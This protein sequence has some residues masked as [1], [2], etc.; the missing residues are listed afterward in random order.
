[1]RE[2]DGERGGE[3]EGGR[4]G[5]GERERRRVCVHNSLKLFIAIVL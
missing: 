2:R 3:G 4:G 1:M 5:E